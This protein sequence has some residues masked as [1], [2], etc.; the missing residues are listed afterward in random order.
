VLHILLIVTL[1]LSF[2]LHQNMCTNSE[3]PQHVIS[4]IHILIFVPYENSWEITNS[5]KCT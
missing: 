2:C 5:V 4:I 1:I 3:V